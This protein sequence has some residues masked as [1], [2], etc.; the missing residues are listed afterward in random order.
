MLAVE[1]FE[2]EDH[3][4]YEVW[5]MVVILPVLAYLVIMNFS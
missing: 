5:T 1:N 3:N 4:E 2:G